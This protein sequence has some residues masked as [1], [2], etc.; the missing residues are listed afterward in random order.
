MTAVY[1]L[2]PGKLKNAALLLGSLLFYAWGEPEYVFLMGLSVLLGY[3]FGLLVEQYRGR[4][5]GRIFC[6][7][8]ILASLSLDRKSVV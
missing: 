2:V 6:G 4:R 1:F 8:S 7:I 5:P 3:G